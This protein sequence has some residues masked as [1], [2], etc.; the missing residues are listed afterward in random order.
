M[1]RF[2]E[3]T[4]QEWIAAPVPQV[5]SQ[6]ADLR[7]HISAQVHPKLS[8]EILRQS[9]HSAR[10]VQHVRLLGIRQRDVFERC[11]ESDGSMTD[12]SVEGFNKG[13]SIDVRFKPHDRG[14]VHGTTVTINVKLPLPPLIG[15]LLKPLLESQIRR[16]VR[17]AAAE[18]KH[19]IELRGYAGWRAHVQS[20][21]QPMAA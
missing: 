11:F 7:H 17:A 15:G 2:A 13:G 16:E 8:F 19:D 3:V 6:F 10:F 18:H 1:R 21:A 5:R 4:H 9:A 20:E 14:A 12:I